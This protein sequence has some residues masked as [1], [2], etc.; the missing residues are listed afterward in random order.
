MSLAWTFDAGSVEIL[1]NIAAELF[2]L[3]KWVKEKKYKPPGDLPWRNGTPLS[4][5]SL[6][7]IPFIEELFATTEEETSRLD[8]FNA[9]AEA[10]L[11]HSPIPDI[12]RW[13]KERGLAAT[14]RNGAPV[15]AR[16]GRP[17]PCRRPG[18]CEASR[19]RTTRG[20]RLGRRTKHPGVLEVAAHR[21]GGLPTHARRGGRATTLDRFGFVTGRGT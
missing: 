19:R 13:R 6:G 2:P 5:K 8:R 1:E 12:D 18:R 17:L 9:I 3:A 21:R 11:S 4:P 20:S 7:V 14:P 15:L 10:P 16:T